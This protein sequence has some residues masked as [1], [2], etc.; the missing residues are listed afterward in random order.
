MVEISEVLKIIS[1]K[2]EKGLDLG[3]SLFLTGMSGKT[4]VQGS[5][6]GISSSTLKL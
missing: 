6:C 5:L 4:L 2:I 1:E 3:V